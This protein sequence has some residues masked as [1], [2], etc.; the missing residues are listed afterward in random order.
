MWL[1]LKNCIYF[2]PI[3]T[4]IAS[5]PRIEN[6]AQQAM[7]GPASSPL[8]ITFQTKY[9]SRLCCHVHLTAYSVSQ[10]LLKQK[11][12]KGVIPGLSL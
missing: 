6:T 7:R 11:T 8:T 4:E 9:T 12:T 10:A 2:Q 5:D 3:E 1:C